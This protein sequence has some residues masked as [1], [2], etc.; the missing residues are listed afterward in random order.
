MPLSSSSF[1]PLHCAHLFFFTSSISHSLF[2]A[3]GELSKTHTWGTR[4]LKED[5]S[6]WWTSARGKA[7]ERQREKDRIVG[8]RVRTREEWTREK[9]ESGMISSDS[10]MPSNDGARHSRELADGFP[11]LARFFFAQGCLFRFCEM[12]R[13]SVN[14]N[15]SPC[16]VA[17]RPPLCRQRG[18]STWPPRPRLRGPSFFSVASVAFA[19]S[20]PPV[21]AFRIFTSPY[22]PPVLASFKL[23]Q[24]RS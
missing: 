23:L 7:R 19:S 18:R 10:C 12:M 24:A 8:K 2:P 16:I 20:P 1:I 3:K 13:R 11:G 6:R 4:K 5:C 15:Y 14:A 21:C 17:A 22:S 9:K